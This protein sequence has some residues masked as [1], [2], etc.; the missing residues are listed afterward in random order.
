MI[1]PTEWPSGLDVVN[2]TNLVYFSLSQRAEFFAL[3]GTFLSKLKMH[4]EAVAAFS[5]ACQIESNLSFAWGAWGTY[6]DELF[7]ELPK[8]RD[9]EG[10]K[11][12]ADAINCYM[13][14]ASLHNGPKSRKFMARI[15]WLLS[16]DDPDQLISKAYEAFKGE[17]PTWY[18]I[19]FIPQLLTALSNKEGKYARLIL[20]KLAK[21]FPQAYFIN[22][23]ASFPT[24]NYKR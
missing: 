4:D 22:I 18:W 15:L 3:K 12:A 23:G 24:S 7:K 20:M 14:A 11:Y 1:S 10:T 19:T 9:S 13:H 17:A 5:S 16:L 21:S 6:N 2:N 8:E